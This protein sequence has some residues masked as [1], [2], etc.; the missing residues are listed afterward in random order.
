MTAKPKKSP[1]RR[2]VEILTLVEHSTQG[3]SVA[4]ICGQLGIEVATVY[5][6]LTALRSL[7]ISLH[8]V[9]G[10]CTLLRPVAPQQYEAL[11]ERY[12]R[13]S[14]HTIGFP[15]NIRFLVQRKN[16]ESVYF[17]TVFVNAIE[18]GRL[19]Q[20]VYRKYSNG[21]TVQRILEPYDLVAS[22]RDWRVVGKVEGVYKIYYLQN[23]AS[24]TMLEKR[25]TRDKT[26]DRVEVFRHAVNFF[27][28]KEHIP[29]ALAVDASIAAKV[30]DELMVDR[31]DRMSDREGRVIVRTTAS[32]ADEFVKWV[33]GFGGLVEVLAPPMI[34]DRV[35]QSARS[36]LKRYARHDR[37]TLTQ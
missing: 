30:T 24:V 5:R 34:R 18:S 31:S 27:R 25:F 23:I 14:I 1:D 21:E 22:H 12:I 3:L 37:E 17:F 10:R 8:S 36:I 35:I 20:I 15:Q 29:V 32:S 13:A 28:G 2:L 26:Y 33:V 4:D 16:A 11:L 19:V 7:G 6:D 9:N